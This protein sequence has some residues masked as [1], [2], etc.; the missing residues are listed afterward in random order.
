[1]VKDGGPELLDGVENR[2]SIEGTSEVT[3][4]YTARL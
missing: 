3:A 4:W 2:N 1:M